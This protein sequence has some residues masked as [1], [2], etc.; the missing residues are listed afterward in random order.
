VSVDPISTASVITIPM[1]T[2]YGAIAVLLDVAALWSI[3]RSPSHSR[4]AKTFWTVA[5]IL[6]PMLGA[7]GW[8]LLGRERRRPP[9]P[10]ADS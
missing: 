3:W 6:L 8:L 2:I 4:R 10:D 7:L 9:S 1:R 5:V